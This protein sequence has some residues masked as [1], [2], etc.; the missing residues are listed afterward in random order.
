MKTVTNTVWTW[1]FVLADAGG[2]VE[3]HICVSREAY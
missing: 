2:L 1:C 3:Y